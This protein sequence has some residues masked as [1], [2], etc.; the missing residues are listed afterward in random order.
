VIISIPS[1]IILTVFSFRV[2]WFDSFQRA[3][4]FR[5]GVLPMSAR[6]LTGLP[7]GIQTTCICTTPIT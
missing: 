4:A 3:D 2:G 6:A 1:V 5:V 7:L